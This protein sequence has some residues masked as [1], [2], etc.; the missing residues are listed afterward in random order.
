MCHQVVVLEYIPKEYDSTLRDEVDEQFP[1]ELAL[2]TKI[3][4][5]V[6]GRCEIVT[7]PDE[8]YQGEI[9][10]GKKEGYGC[11][12]K[13]QNDGN[14]IFYVG[15]FKNN[16]FHGP[17]VLRDSSLLYTGTFKNGLRNGKIKS[18]TV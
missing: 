5:D 15:C 17:G 8:K 7:S 11:L 9:N 4:Y 14:K 18:L 2:E 12:V 3:Y 6:L 10:E 13:T 16:L 1:D